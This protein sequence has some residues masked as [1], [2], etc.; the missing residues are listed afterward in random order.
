MIKEKGTLK[1]VIFSVKNA[2]SNDYAKMF[3]V[4]KF[5]GVVGT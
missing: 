4:A 2:V 1:F 3:M 5:A